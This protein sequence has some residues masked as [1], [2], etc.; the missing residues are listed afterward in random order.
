MSEYKIS[1]KAA[2]VN[3]GKT[4]EEAA[5]A[6]KVAKQTIVSW[7]TGKTSPT[8]EMARKYCEFC[9]A[10]YDAISFLPRTAI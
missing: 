10:P 7:E 9:G 2:R 3:A 4:Q 6:L 8:V 1:M 5:K